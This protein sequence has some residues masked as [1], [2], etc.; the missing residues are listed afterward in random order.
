V[1]PFGARDCVA[2][3]AALGM[4]PKCARAQFERRAQAAQLCAPDLGIA[5]VV[6]PGATPRT[7]SAAKVRAATSSPP[8]HEPEAGSVGLATA[9]SLR[10]E[11]G[12]GDGFPVKN[13][14]VT[15]AAKASAIRIVKTQRARSDGRPTGIL[16]NSPLF[17]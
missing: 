15:A 5:G 11:V 2:H 16:T 13:S 4:S 3:S 9:Q 1:Q 14:G 7:S 10:S 8:S 17:C 6:R 12:A